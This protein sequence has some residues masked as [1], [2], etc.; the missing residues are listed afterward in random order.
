M[1]ESQSNIRFKLQWGERK[2]WNLR[3]NYNG[4]KENIENIETWY[5]I[6]KHNAC[7]RI[8]YHNY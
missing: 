5:S 3:L 2:H 1:I 4:E 7:F 6:L 8:E